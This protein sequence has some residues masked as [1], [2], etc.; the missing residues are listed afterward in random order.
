MS[1]P[2]E[3]EIRRVTGLE[4]VDAMLEV[5]DQAFATNPINLAVMECITSDE[6][7]AIQR[8]LKRNRLLNAMEGRADKSLDFHWGKAVYIPRGNASGGEKAVAF[9]GFNAPAVVLDGATMSR[10]EPPPHSPNPAREDIPAEVLKAG[11]IMQNLYAGLLG[12]NSD[13]LMGTD[14]DAHYWFLSSLETMPEH[15]RRGLGTKLVQRS[16]DLARADAKARPGTIKGVWTIATPSGLKT[17]LKAGMK[18][19]GSEVIDFGKGGG[20]NGQ[21][22]V[23]LLMKFD[24]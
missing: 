20:V 7:R 15:Q 17:Y 10:A 14:R 9:I 24:E 6:N 3:Y 19:I 4:D 2:P 13:E 1:S 12:K 22:Y 5:E 18:E 23:W 8:N 21:K 11:Q 16:I